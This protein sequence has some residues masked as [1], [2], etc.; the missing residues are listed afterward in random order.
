MGIMLAIGIKLM[1][2]PE[3]YL[4]YHTVKEL[5]FIVICLIYLSIILFFVAIYVQI[6]RK[7]YYNKIG[8]IYRSWRVV[9][10]ILLILIF[11]SYLMTDYKVVKFIYLAI[12]LFS[13]RVHTFDK[14]KFEII[15]HE[16]EK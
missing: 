10:F 15:K 3:T 7:S 5:H 12:L 9:C 6:H 8:K 11:P 14:S 1:L 13:L 16:D 2:S 4:N